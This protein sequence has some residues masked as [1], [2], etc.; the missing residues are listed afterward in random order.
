MHLGYWA[1]SELL[2]QQPSQLKCQCY[3]SSISS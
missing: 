1:F 3:V 2:C